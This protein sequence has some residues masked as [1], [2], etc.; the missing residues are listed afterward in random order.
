MAAKLF[1][2]P[3]SLLPSPPLMPPWPTNRA[4]NG[5]S[6]FFSFHAMNARASPLSRNSREFLILWIDRCESQSSVAVVFRRQTLGKWS[7]NVHRAVDIIWHYGAD[8]R[9]TLW[10]SRKEPKVRLFSSSPY[11]RHDVIVLSFDAYIA[12]CDCPALSFFFFHSF[13]V[14]LTLRD[15]DGMCQPISW[16]SPLFHSAFVTGETRK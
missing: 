2:L 16:G 6:S 5:R 10:L 14:Y 12:S 4:S 8:C 11:A 7:R 15:E 1:L 13:L 3:P 9:V